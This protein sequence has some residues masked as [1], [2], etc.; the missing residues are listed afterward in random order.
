MRVLLVE[1]DARIARG[2][3]SALEGAGYAVDLAR[4]A[5]PPGSTATRRITTSRCWISACQKWTGSPC[6][7]DGAAPAAASRS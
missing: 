4:D 7:G 2:V 5:R 6:C 1:D 3:R